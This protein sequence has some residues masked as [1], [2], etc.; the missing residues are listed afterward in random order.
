MENQIDQAAKGEILIY[1]SSRN[2]VTIDVRLEK[3]SVWLS[4]N[5]IASLFETDK[6][7]ISTHINNIYKS[8]ELDLDS[9]V[10]KIATVQTEGK[11]KVT[12]DIAES[13]PKEKETMIN[14]IQHLIV[15]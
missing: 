2:E 11:R 9:T 15:D 1:K 5:Q 10:A 14:I 7:G 3:E 4:L 12:R 6:S 8:N 13:A